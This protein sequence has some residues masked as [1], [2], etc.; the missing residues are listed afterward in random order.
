MHTLPTTP[1]RIAIS[2]VS[3]I[4]RERTTHL[5]SQAFEAVGRAFSWADLLERGAAFALLVLA[6]P[7]ILVLAAYVRLVDGAPVFYRGERLG[8]GKKP[9]TMIKI[10]TLRREAE[11]ITA[12]RLIESRDGLE[13]P[14]GRWLRESRLDELPQ[15]WNVVRGDMRFI[16]PR[17][18][19][20]RVYLAQCRAIP[21]YAQR[22]A[23]RPGLIGPS[24]LFTPHATDKRLRCW[25]D[26]AWCRRPRSA[27]ELVG[28]CAYTV[29]AVL[30]KA[31]TRALDT[32]VA[33][34]RTRVGAGRAGERRLR[35]VRPAGVHVTLGRPGARA[36]LL[37]LSEESLRL[38]T[39]A[40]LRVGAEIELCL[41]IRLGP[42]A[43]APLRVAR[44]TAVVIA[45]REGA[46][47]RE[48]VLRHSAA[49]PYSHYVLHQYFLGNSLARPHSLRA[50]RRRIA[51][52]VSFPDAR[53]AHAL[54][55]TD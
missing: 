27:T 46:K 1:R 36:E 35:R 18:E 44:L 15:L 41:T 24:Q 30:R 45:R 38:Q 49:S 4:P 55:G 20:R 14:G 29:L 43:T 21:R 5:A 28:L 7:V 19:R 6:T 33:W 47:R 17:P 53:P 37:D 50:L 54:S 48:L 42:G 52:P 31:A 8:K 51:R 32:H 39:S 3:A 13:L 9:F 12:D 34:W 40:P 22:F 2:R 26:N 11:Q 16:G 25:L 10:R 23:V